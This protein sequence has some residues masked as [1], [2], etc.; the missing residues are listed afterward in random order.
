[1][2]TINQHGTGHLD[3]TNDVG[4]FH[5]VNLAFG[6]S[7]IVNTFLMYAR[8]NI[9]KVSVDFLVASGEP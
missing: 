4:S 1:M 7:P 6:I 2:H 9:L 3:E 5:V 8:H